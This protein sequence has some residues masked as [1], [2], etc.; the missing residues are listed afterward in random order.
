MKRG[1]KSTIIILSTV[2]IIGILWSAC[3]DDDDD[4]DNNN[5]TGETDDDTNNTT[6]E[7]L[8]YIQCEDG[9]ITPM[10]CL[11]GYEEDAACEQWGEE[12]CNV[13]GCALADF[14]VVTTCT[15][16]SNCPDQPEWYW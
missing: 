12:R 1:I 7:G 6:D 8:C 13:D 11:S 4:D 16:C 10:A 5:D 2:L 9:C 14:E 3:G 15:E